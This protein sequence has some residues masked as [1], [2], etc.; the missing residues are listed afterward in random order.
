MHKVPANPVY[1]NALRPR[2]VMPD[3]CLH[4]GT[5]HVH[6]VDLPCLY[7]HHIQTLFLPV[8]IQRHRIIQALLD[9]LVIPPIHGELADVVAVAEYQL[10][11]DICKE[12]PI[13]TDR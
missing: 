13:N 8:E 11:L 12:M 10:W 9:Q 5:V 4:S 7:V 6:S 3:Q 2:Q 1:S